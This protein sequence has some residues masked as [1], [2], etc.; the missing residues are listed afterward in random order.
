M[1]EKLI[2]FLEEE[3][4]YPKHPNAHE[5]DVSYHL[6]RILDDIVNRLKRDFEEKESLTDKITKKI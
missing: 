1:V 5:I 6:N 4:W 3:K 2:Q